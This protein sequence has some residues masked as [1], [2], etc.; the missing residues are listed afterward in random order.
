MKESDGPDA[1]VTSLILRDGRP[2]NPRFGIL[3][4]STYA[5]KQEA[6]QGYRRAPVVV[7]LLIGRVSR[8][9]F[10][11]VVRAHG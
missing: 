11:V 4:L 2:G 9:L 8:P 1:D 10:S 5:R 7:S 6:L 3:R